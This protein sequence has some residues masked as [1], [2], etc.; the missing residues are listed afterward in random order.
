MRRILLLSL[1]FIPF[2]LM[3]QDYEGFYQKSVNINQTGMY[4]LGGW[5]LA[6]IASGAYGWKS[7]DGQSK[8]FH[9]MNVMWNAVNLGIAG[10]GVYSA[11]NANPS[12]MSS[13]EMLA[14]H[15]KTENIY[16]INAGIDVLYV[17]GGYYL[18]RLALSKPQKHDLYRGY[19]KSVMLQG[20]FLFVF[21]LIMYGIQ[22]QHHSKFLDAIAYVNV[23]SHSL[24]LGFYLQ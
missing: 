23:S 7:Y 10:F 12:L 11:L 2:V 17:A 21:D 24:C 18:T 22:S 14:E 20:A 1:L 16:L 13:L 19:G 3:A 8:Y 4:V 6:N 15:K 5:A 9:Q